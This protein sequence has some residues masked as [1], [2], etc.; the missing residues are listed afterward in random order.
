MQWKQGRAG[1]ASS[2][3]QSAHP[4]R[5]AGQSPS[6]QGDRW[7]RG[8]PQITGGHSCHALVTSLPSSRVLSNTRHSQKKTGSGH[9]FLLP[10]TGDQSHQTPQI[11]VSSGHPG[12]PQITITAHSP[13][14]R[15][16]PSP[17]HPLQEEGS[18]NISTSLSNGMPAYPTAPSEQE[19]L[20][21]PVPPPKEIHSHQPSRQ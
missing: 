16:H 12:L 20:L 15:G 14:H 13:D 21:V 9:E 17:P 7:D 10:E 2:Q 1:Q 6:P 8:T 18:L 19:A 3:S 11:T 5:G 4:A